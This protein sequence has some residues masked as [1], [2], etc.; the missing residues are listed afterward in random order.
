VAPVGA[1]LERAFRLE[2]AILPLQG[3]AAR[4]FDGNVPAT[5]GGALPPSRRVVRSTIVSVR[6]VRV[7]IEAVEGP[8]AVLKPPMALELLVAASE[9][10]PAPVPTIPCQSG[11]GHRCHCQ[12]HDS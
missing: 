6:I 8:V 9:L 7:R 10:M 3:E 4:N 2:E 5:D 11:Y 1:E 12:D